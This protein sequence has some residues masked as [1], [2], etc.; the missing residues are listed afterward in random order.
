[1][2]R[3]ISPLHHTARWHGT[4]LCRGTTS[5]MYRTL[6]ITHKLQGYYNEEHL[7]KKN[8]CVSTSVG[9]GSPLQNVCLPRNSLSN[10]HGC[11]SS[12]M[13]S[14]QSHLCARFSNT[15]RSK[16]TYCCSCQMERLNKIPC[17]H[18]SIKQLHTEGKTDHYSCNFKQNTKRRYLRQL[19][20][21]IN[22]IEEHAACIFRDEV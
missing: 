20:T 9:H 6:I 8:R 12:K 18:Y 3:V 22:V 5:C 7:K 1:M 16:S 4:W 11:N 14:L 21:D 19:E 17:R 2:L 13:K 15:L 10:V